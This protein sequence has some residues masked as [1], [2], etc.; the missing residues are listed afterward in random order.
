[1]KTK[2]KTLFFTLGLPLTVVGCNTP[3]AVMI[4]KTPSLTPPQLVLL[5][6]AEGKAKGI[7]IWD[8]P[9]AFGPVPRDVQ[10]PGDV[11]CMLARID[12]QAIGY[13]P[14]AKGVDGMPLQGGGYFC[15][16]KPHGSQPSKLPPKLT[17][18]DGVLGWDNPAA[19]GQVP[20][21]MK[22]EGAIA[23]GTPMTNNVAYGYHPA[24]LDENG[25]TIKGGGFF[26][27]SAA[28][29]KN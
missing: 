5:A 1:M 28:A 3:A 12:L 4:G 20:E 18:I 14:A 7:Y 15:G 6:T 27:V 23:C 10:V 24:A 9:L 26:C 17:R 11:S 19:F 16:P 21:S 13:H 8:N 2:I 25:N 22:E 29:L